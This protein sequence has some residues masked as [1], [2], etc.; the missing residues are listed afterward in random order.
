MLIKTSFSYGARIGLVQDQSVCQQNLSRLLKALK[1]HLK[2]KS[3]ISSS[4][5]SSSSRLS[6]TISAN[7]SFSNLLSASA[8][9]DI[10]GNRLSMS[11]YAAV[12][13]IFVE[14]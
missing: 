4:N 1:T 12:I 6:G 5:T 10:G 13:R 2:Q 9:G 11:N 3:V 7:S 8:L 14:L